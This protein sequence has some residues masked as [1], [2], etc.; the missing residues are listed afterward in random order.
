MCE[1]ERR[2]L[3]SVLR[4]DRWILSIII[5]LRELAAGWRPDWDA[6]C[7]RR[8]PWGQQRE[9]RTVQCVGSPMLTRACLPLLIGIIMEKCCARGERE[10]ARADSCSPSSHCRVQCAHTWST[11]HTHEPRFLGGTQ[12]FVR[13]PDSRPEEQW[14]SP[15]SAGVLPYLLRAYSAKDAV[16]VHNRA[17][18]RSP[19]MCR[20]LHFSPTT[21]SSTS[22]PRLTDSGSV[23]IVEVAILDA[24]TFTSGR[25]PFTISTQ[26]RRTAPD[27]LCH[28]VRGRRVPRHPDRPAH[29]GSRA[30]RRRPPLRPQF[31]Y[32]LD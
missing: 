19:F 9:K 13:A 30:R 14:A 5:A 1:D 11:P 8:W 23:A 18:F 29:P 4:G 24:V 31:D 22:P 27:T 2:L 21:T 7:A 20:S 15:Y 12:V 28:H 32:R 16:H 17:V 6:C 26:V 10:P 3:S 25:P